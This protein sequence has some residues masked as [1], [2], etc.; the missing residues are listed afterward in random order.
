MNSFHAQLESDLQDKNVDLLDFWRCKISIR[1]LSVLMEQ[2]P[3][4]SRYKSALGGHSAQW[5]PGDYIAA[6][7]FDAYAAV[8][9]K[10]PQPY[11]RPGDREREERMMARRRKMWRDQFLKNGGEL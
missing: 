1:K 6:D 5:R 11:P 9:F 7:R 8:N 4:E 10:D 3:V 2:L